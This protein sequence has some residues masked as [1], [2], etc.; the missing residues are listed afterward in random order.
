MSGPTRRR[1]PTL[2]TVPTTDVD[3][4]RGVDRSAIRELLALTPAE[5][6]DRLIEIVNVWS[7]L[8][9]HTSRRTAES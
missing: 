3:D 6:L 7:E 9:S 4:A 2:A 1:R 8:R 5:R